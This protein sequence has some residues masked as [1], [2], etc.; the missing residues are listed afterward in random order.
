MKRIA[1][2]LLTLLTLAPAARAALPF[3]EDDYSTAMARAK[4]AHVPLFVEAWAPW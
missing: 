3:V 1:F 4:T 2:L